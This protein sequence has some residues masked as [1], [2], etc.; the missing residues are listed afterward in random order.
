MSDKIIVNVERGFVDIFTTDGYVK[1][2][3]ISKYN[4]IEIVEKIK[5]F[6]TYREIDENGNTKNE[7]QD[8]EIFLDSLNC[9]AWMSDLLSDIGL[10]YTLVKPIS[11]SRFDKQREYPYYDAC[12]VLEEMSKDW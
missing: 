9:G 10:E 5:N 1:S 4:M 12:K 2:F 7:T 8:V 6:T 11:S 3:D